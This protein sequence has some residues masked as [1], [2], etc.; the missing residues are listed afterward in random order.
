MKKLMLAAGLV[1]FAFLASPSRASAVP[2]SP[3]T[4]CP[5]VGLNPTGCQ[6]LVVFN[7]DGSI[8]TFAST[9]D[10]GPYDGSEDT[11]IGVQ[12]D[13]ASPI[14]S[15]TLGPGVGVNG[16]GP[17]GFD[18]DGACAAIGCGNASDPSGYG[19]LTSDIQ[20][21]T[22]SNIQNV[23]VF[24][25]L[26]TVNFGANGIPAGGSAWFSLEDSF[27][28]TQLPPINGGAVPEPG[29]LV[30]LGTGALALARRM[31]KGKR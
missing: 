7:A 29:T 30:L 10:T 22:Y 24:A 23:I 13:T 26:G 21:V 16:L 11:L 15:L 20:D 4:Q 31:K 28:L 25:D 17:F 9:T 19:G 6:F 12:N 18:G 27:N 2:L 5:P 14:L 1:A 3:F 8:E